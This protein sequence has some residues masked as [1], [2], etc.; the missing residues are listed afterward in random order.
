MWGRAFLVCAI[1]SGL[2]FAQNAGF[3]SA[4][5]LNRSA[6][7]K[8]VY[9]SDY[10]WRQLPS[11]NLG[12]PGPVSITLAPCPLGVDTANEGFQPYFVYIANQ[13]IPEAMQ[14]TGGTC[15]SGP[16][17]GTIL[18]MTVNS[19]RPGYT[20][21]SASG[22][23]QEA[24]NAAGKNGVIFLTPANPSDPD[25][26]YDIYAP[27]IIHG[28]QQTINAYGAVLRCQTRSR[29][30]NLGLIAPG[31][32]NRYLSIKWFGGRFQAGTNVDGAQISGCSAAN[33]KWTCTTATAH[34]FART[35]PQDTANVHVF[36]GAPC[37]RQLDG[38]FPVTPTGATTFSFLWGKATCDS[39]S[40]YGWTALLNTAIDDNA[41]ASVIRDA[42]A[43]SLGDPNRW[44][45]FI[46]VENDQALEIDH[47]S[48]EGSG[49]V[50]RNDANFVGAMIY[51][52]GN[53]S[54]IFWAH[55]VELSM[56]GGGN[57]VLALSGNT[58]K[59]SDSVI[60]GFS[61]YAMICSNSFNN[62]NGCEVDNI[63]TEVGAN[64][65]NP[66]TPGGT[67]YGQAGYIGLGGAGPHILSGQLEP[68]GN[69]PR[70]AR[71]GSTPINYWVV[72]HSS[73]LGASVPLLIGT[74]ETNGSGMIKGYFPEIPPVNAG[75]ITYDILASTGVGPRQV[76]PYGTSDRAGFLGSVAT[77]I[78]G[79]C[80]TAGYC[81]FSD[82]QTKYSSYTVPAS[83]FY[84]ELAFWPGNVL[85]PSQNTRN[86]ALTSM[87]V[88]NFPPV[89][90]AAGITSAVGA[91]EPTIQSAICAFPVNSNA[92]GI[93]CEQAPV[94]NGS[95]Y[96]RIIDSRNPGN[97][98][99]LSQNRKGALN[100]FAGN[101]PSDVLTLLDANPAKTFS[102]PANRPGWDANDAAFGFDDA[103]GHQLYSRAQTT[104]SNYIGT[105]GDNAS[106]KERLTA[107][108]KTFNVPIALRETSAPKGVPGADV[109]YGD[110][111]AHAEKCS[112]DN[113]TFLKTPQIFAAGQTALGTGAIASGAC[114]ASVTVAAS[115]AT[116]K[117]VVHWSL[118]SD[119]NGVTGYA[120]STTG[121]VLQIYAFPTAGN[122]SFRVCNNTS[123]TIKPGAMSVNWDVIQ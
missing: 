20:V 113:G 73:A 66:F 75:T 74:A 43:S 52:P 92:L 22:G 51:T 40:G 38:V 44:H 76:V 13:G 50:M 71:T 115:G 101:L 11:D 39:S 108:L 62:Y 65:V 6:S 33:G 28:N 81:S 103:S 70:F 55:N 82:P 35:G 17:R 21:Q 48:N 85:G 31:S 18:G 58:S 9:A 57:G 8:Q 83:T 4:G 10:N 90:S 54:G 88:V 23:I 2:V 34:N 26:T 94:Q 120:G 121:A 118:A 110:S 24:S 91:F 53:N 32:V 41:D 64:T 25:A 117:S 27:V 56:Q 95:W 100:I 15:T 99:P 7:S 93:S 86:P 111:T 79:N 61:Q 78:S 84:P 3:D 72:V 5:S 16:A 96:A 98:G 105:V 77:G 63:Y 29:C 67:G 119:P 1:L 122:V 112:Y 37:N 114:A 49:R 109:C 45:Y 89:N 42:I 59:V 97:A 14:V 87:W 116:T 80:T 68:L 123:S 107:S 69:L 36:L 102:T 19:H 12:A 60:Q 30:I 46:T 104:I 47:I 106:Y